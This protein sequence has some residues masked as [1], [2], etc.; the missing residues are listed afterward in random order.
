MTVYKAIYHCRM[1]GAH[2][3]HTTVDHDTALMEA[4]EMVF[5]E[6]TKEFG[7]GKLWRHQTHICCDGSIGFADFLGFRKE[8]TS[9]KEG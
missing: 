7:S 1:C 9:E 5:D 4:T 3:V 2:F 8:V 6:S